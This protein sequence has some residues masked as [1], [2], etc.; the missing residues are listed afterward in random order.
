MQRMDS[1][2]RQPRPYIKPE[3]GPPMSNPN[4]REVR[5][6]PAGGW[7]VINPGGQRA[8]AHCDTQAEAIDRARQIL[9]NT[10]GGELRIAG[11]DGAMRQADTIP[12]GNDS[13]R[14]PG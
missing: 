6:A 3:T 12:P 8:S 4:A 2:G 5:P 9:S 1:C 14:R 13:P 7:N 10:G 11:R